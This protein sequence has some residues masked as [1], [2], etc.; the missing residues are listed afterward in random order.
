MRSRKSGN[1]SMDVEAIEEHARLSWKIIEA[2]ILYFQ[3]KGFNEVFVDKHTPLD[4]DFDKMERRYLELCVELSLPN[5]V[6]EISKYTDLNPTGPGMLEIDFTRPSVQL[7]HSR[8]RS[9]ERE[10]LQKRRAKGSSRTPSGRLATKRTSE[11][12]KATRKSTGKRKPNVIVSRRRPKTV[13]KKA[14]AR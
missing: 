12:K 8:L 10:F 7:A 5:T 1:K 14:R 11:S 13:R 3:S 4:S 2:K 9:L 6:A